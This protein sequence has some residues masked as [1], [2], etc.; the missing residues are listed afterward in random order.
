[1]L[2]AIGDHLNIVK[3]QLKTFIYLV[4]HP[5]CCLEGLAS[6]QYRAFVV[7]LLVAMHMINRSTT[8]CTTACIAVSG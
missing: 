8:A 3:M 5:G 7:L 6:A 1:M 2:S 4:R